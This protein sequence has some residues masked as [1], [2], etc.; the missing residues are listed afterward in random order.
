[1]QITSLERAVEKL[2]IAG[3][4]AGFTVE[5]MIDLLDDGLP[6]SALV[7]MINSWLREEDR[8]Q[9]AHTPLRTQ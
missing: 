3:E 4:Q 5:Q 8:S 2:A 9:H 7:D 6:L 1:M